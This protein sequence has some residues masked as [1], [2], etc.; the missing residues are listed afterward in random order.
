M[1]VAIYR[2]VLKIKKLYFGKIYRPKGYLVFPEESACV[3]QLL[4]DG[5]S[6]EP[7]ED[8]FYNQF[9][10]RLLDE[11]SF[12]MKAVKISKFK[13]ARVLTNLR[14]AV[15]IID[16]DDRILGEYSFTYEM[17][18]DGKFHHAHVSENHFLEETSLDAPLKVSGTVFSML[19]GGGK[20]FNFYHWFFDVLS[21]AVDLKESGWFGEVDYFLVPEY[22]KSFQKESLAFLGITRDKIISSIQY[23]HILADCIIA[24]SHP[25]TATYS[26]RSFH[27]LELK[28]LFAIKSHLKIDP[29]KNYPKKFFVSRSDAPRRK[30]LNE[31]QLSQNLLQNEIHTIKISDYTFQEAI[32]LFR[33]ADWIISTHSAALTNMIF[34][35]SNTK[36]YE[37]FERNGVLPYYYELS[38]SLGM[39]YHTIILNSEKKIPDS[40]YE[41][42]DSDLEIDIEL[43]LQS[44]NYKHV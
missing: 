6:V 39:E 2:F 40:R 20:N 26:V 44:I 17:N 13:N 36:I 23:K 9:N 37:I 1:R 43:V 16:G 18:A 41:I 19:T 27:A 29:T 32:H 38:K 28:S 30:I 34:S 14:N 33:N 8:L 42:Q 7:S 12:E 22:E 11:T 24:S 35:T 3:V 21:R 31:E 15:A 25:R 4:H 5:F 10:E